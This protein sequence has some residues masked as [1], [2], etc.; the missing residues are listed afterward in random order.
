VLARGADIVQS[1]GV[2]SS[3]T[4]SGGVEVVS[5]LAF[6]PIV[7]SGVEYLASGGVASGALVLSAQENIAA[8]AAARGAT[9]SSGGVVLD[10]GGMSAVVLSSGAGAY[11]ATGGGAV[12]TSVRSGAADVVSSGGV[13]SG[14]RLIGGSELVFAGGVTISALIGSGGMDLIEANGIASA[15]TISGGTLELMSG[16][17]TGAGA[18]TFASSGGGILL[19][20]DSVHFGGLVAGFGQPD[21][22]DLRDIAFG[23]STTLSFTPALGNTSGTL[24][25]TDGAHTANIMLLGQYVTGQ[26]TKASDGHGGT[27][28]G[29]PPAVTAADPAPAAMVNPQHA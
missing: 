3:T 7:S 29:D 23:S 10:A 19:L 4:L 18:V 25:V 9:V 15:A 2:A 13:A 27:L 22:L 11:I 12:S 21:F 1:G 5:G 16:A 6:A 24:T 28:I 14:T 8:G 20:D 17:A 26:F